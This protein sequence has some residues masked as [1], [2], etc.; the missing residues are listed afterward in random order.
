MPVRP[1]EM[2]DV[3]S[4]SRI[5]Q[6]IR[7]ILDQEVRRLLASNS[8]LDAQVTSNTSN[9]SANTNA[10]SSND[11]DIDEIM[12]RLYGPGMGATTYGRDPVETA[13]RRFAL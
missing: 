1:R 4:E 10:I 9:I 2:Q 7:S 13:I 6:V 8:T 11:D 3:P 5:R 12:R